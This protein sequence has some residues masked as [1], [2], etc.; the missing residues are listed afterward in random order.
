[1]INNLN[2]NFGTN[3]IAPFNGDPIKKKTWIEAVAKHA[4]LERVQ[5]KT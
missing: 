4:L 2:P 5:R 1:M 3:Q